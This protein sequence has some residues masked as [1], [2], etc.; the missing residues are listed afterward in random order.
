MTGAPTAD[1]PMISVLLCQQ[2]GEE[3]PHHLRLGPEGIVE[4]V[5]TACGRVVSLPQR[6]SARV[7]LGPYVL[8]GGAPVLVYARVPA[9]RAGA[10]L[11]GT[12]RRLAAAGAHVVEVD[13]RQAEE[14]V[15]RRLAGEIPVALVANAGRGFADAYKLVHHPH[16][17]RVDGLAAVRWL[18]DGEEGHLR[19]VLTAAVQRRVPLVVAVPLASASADGFLNALERAS[20]PL[21]KTGLASV[22]LEFCHADP[23]LMMAACEQAA[24]RLP[25]PFVVRLAQGWVEQASAERV[26]P[27]L[28]TFLRQRRCDGLAVES[29]ED[30]V[31][32][33]GAA[34]RL[35]AELWLPVAAPPPQV[36]VS[37]AAAPRAPLPGAARVLDTLRTAASVPGRVVEG[38]RSPQVAALP[39]RVLTK[40]V[41]FWH[42]VQRN[43]AGVFLTVPRRLAT[44]PVRLVRELVGHPGRGA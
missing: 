16:A 3:Q 31:T 23:A 18:Y 10:A 1:R 9:G 12:V 11:A 17:G 42:E 4:T 2:C 25:C 36:E 7:A 15:T 35:L 5:C 37:V 13:A 22:V 20:G 14:A 19:L 24:E 34:W 29:R 39:S 21:G 26:P 8:G 6:R 40:P 38:L 27:A 33:V 30:P 32:G 44:K 43:G 41:R 28:G